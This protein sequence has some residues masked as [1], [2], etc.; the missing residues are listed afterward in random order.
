MGDSEGKGL[1]KHEQGRLLE[2][3]GLSHEH[4]L[5]LGGRGLGIGDSGDGSGWE[6]DEV[7]R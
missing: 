7:T 2:V 3:V 4:V 6:F 5:Q 1:G